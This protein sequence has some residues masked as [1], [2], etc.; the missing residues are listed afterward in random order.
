[1]YVWTHA[2]CVLSVLGSALEPRLTLIS[3][4]VPLVLDSVVGIQK[5]SSSYF[6]QWTEALRQQQI[7]PSTAL[8]TSSS[9]SG[10]FADRNLLYF[11]TCVF[12]CS[13]FSCCFHTYLISRSISV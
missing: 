9:P 6:Q 4:M 10:Q 11:I 1:M 13:V 5:K 7:H 3:T 2:I 8:L 12:T